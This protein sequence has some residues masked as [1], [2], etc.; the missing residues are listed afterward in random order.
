M[1]NL[2][3]VDGR[4]DDPALTAQEAALLRDT[5]VH[6]FAVGVGQDIDMSELRTLASAP[7]DQYVNTV[8][9][10]DA[11][12]TIKELLAIK[13]CQGTCILCMYIDQRI[14]FLVHSH[15]PFCE[16]FPMCLTKAFCSVFI[17][18]FFFG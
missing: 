11:L 16:S 9:N 13:A 7:A 4:S 2:Y 1:W 12:T 8:D 15:K 10:Y 3:F 6:V 14:G 18:F 17:S 5:G